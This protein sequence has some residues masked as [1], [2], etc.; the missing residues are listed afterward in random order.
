MTRI[1]VFIQLNKGGMS[2]QLDAR[3]A[4]YNSKR[5]TALYYRFNNEKAFT[6][7]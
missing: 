6:L 3:L 1:M 5:G 2:L 4:S 7:N